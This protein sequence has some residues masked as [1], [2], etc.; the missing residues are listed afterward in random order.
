[1]HSV[2][3]NFI[4][5]AILTVSSFIFPLITFPYISRTLLV[6][7]I[8]KV[9]FATSVISYFTMFA[10]LGIPTYGIRACARVRDDREK[11]TKTAQELIII[12]LITSAITYAVFFILLFTVDRFY[13]DK[14]LLTVTS[15]SIILNTLGVTW[16]YSALEQYSYITVRN[17]ACK[18]VSVILMFIFVHNTSDYVIYGVIAVLASGGSNLLNFINL[19]NIFRAP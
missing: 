10:S 14:T 9:N 2:Q 4:M 13:Q 18:L 19:K 3:F 17:I 7:G 1:M 6:D 11:L 15:V 12:N 5:N 16:L 8:G